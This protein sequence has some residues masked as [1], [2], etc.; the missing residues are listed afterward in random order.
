MYRRLCELVAITGL[1]FLVNQ[2]A[3]LS[4]CPWQTVR[5]VS[6]S[7]LLKPRAWSFDTCHAAQNIRIRLSHVRNNTINATNTSFENHNNATS[8]Y[9]SINILPK[10]TKNSYAVS[11]FQ[12]CTQ[13][14]EYLQYEPMQVAFFGCDAGEAFRSCCGIE[15]IIAINRRMSLYD[16][17]T[18]NVWKLT[19]S[20]MDHQLCS[21]IND[22]YFL[23]I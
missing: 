20:I 4:S 10:A 7:D 1:T 5:A 9:H 17:R 19:Y 13:F 23:A 11:V 16:S 2:V 6:Q 3:D 22:R 18:L 21:H 8:I 14:T 12:T 15:L